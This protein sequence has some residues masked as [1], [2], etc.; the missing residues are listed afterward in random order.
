MR[1]MLKRGAPKEEE[2]SKERKCS[3]DCFKKKCRKKSRKRTFVE[4]IIY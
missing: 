2:E 4:R 3:H 1:K